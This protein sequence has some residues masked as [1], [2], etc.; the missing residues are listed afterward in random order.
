MTELTTSPAPHDGGPVVA[1]TPLPGSKAVRLFT[2]DAFTSV[3]FRGNPA[4]VCILQDQVDDEL[5]QSIAFEMNLA[6]TAFVSGYEAGPRAGGPYGLRWFTPARE[7]DLCG[8]AT[9]A[10]AHVLFCELGIDAGQVDFDTR[11]G[12]LTVVRPGTGARGGPE[13]PAE[14]GRMIM[15]FPSFQVRP[16]P[17]PDDLAAVLGLPA[18]ER[19]VEVVGSAFS[20]RPLVICRYQGAEAVLRAA[21]DFGAF[22]GMDLGALVLT[23]PGEVSSSY[24]F[25]S[26][27]F[28]PEFGIPEDPV[29]GSAHSYLAPYWARITGKS[30]LSAYQASRRGGEVHCRVGGDRV[31]LG[32][33]AVTVIRGEIT[34]RH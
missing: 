1:S 22:S 24:D 16:V 28:A 23:A 15:S 10:A 2:V 27:F 31:A 19:P 29:T 5:L 17:E 25:V 26:R 20:G 30:E 33:N 7:V 13:D 34:F 14:P 3:P 18:D 11:S 12:R 6:E 21:P 9:L 32:G 8:H 4:A